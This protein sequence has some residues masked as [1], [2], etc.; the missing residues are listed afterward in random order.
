LGVI[1]QNAQLTARPKEIPAWDD[2]TPDQKKL[3]Q[4]K[5]KPL[6]ALPNIQIIKL[7]GWLMH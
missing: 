7:E 1:P 5:W 4:G 2:Q 6:Q 3:L